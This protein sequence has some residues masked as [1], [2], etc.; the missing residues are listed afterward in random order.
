M[1]NHAPSN[2]YEGNDI[3]NFVKMNPSFEIIQQAVTESGAGDTGSTFRRK[4]P[5]D[6][7]DHLPTEAEVQRIMNTES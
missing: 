4:R 2:D 5:T 6:E 3:N 7:Y 1:L